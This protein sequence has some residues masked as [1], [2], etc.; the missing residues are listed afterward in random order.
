MV[1]VASSPAS[2]SSTLHHTAEIRDLFLSRATDDLSGLRPVVARSWRRSRAAGVDS[3][4][5]RGYIDEGRVDERTM[6]TA[7]PHL[8]KL[9]EVARDIG[10]Y[11]SLSSPNGVLVKPTFLREDADF[12]QGYSLLEAS[13]G[14]NAEGVALEEG[15]AVW[16]S[17]EEH[18]REDMRCNWCF[19]SLIR[20]PFHNRV[21]AVVGLTLPAARVQRLDPSSTLLM[22][23][24]VTSRIER[25][26]ETR[27]SSRERTL[28][29]EYLT[30][31]RRRG[32]AAVV[33]TD[34]KHS[35]MNS[36]ATASLEGSD[37]SVVTSYAKSVMS[38]GRDT[39]V[40][41]MLAGFGPASLEVSPVDLSASGF[42]AV[43]VVR[44]LARRSRT[45]DAPTVSRHEVP[46]SAGQL[47]ERLDGQSLSL[48]HAVDSARTAVEQRRSVAIIGEP[49]S[50]KTRLAEAIAS[51]RGDV[52]R[53]DA[54][55]SDAGTRIDEAR[56][57]ANTEFEPVLFI[58]HADELSPMDSRDLAAQL[59]GGARRTVIFTA[60]SVTDATRPIADASGALEITL[61]PLRRR[62]EDIPLLAHAI[63]SEVGDRRL[64]RRL[65]ATLT[66]SDWPGNITQLRQVVS[67]AVERSRGIEVSDDDLPESFHRMLTKGR[68]SR[69]EDA[70]LT[71][72][73]SALREAK[74]NR[75][76]AAEILEIGRS[77]FYRRMDYFRSRG[78]DL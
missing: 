7:E 3:Q 44:P 50:G 52:I 34:G 39:S 10:G 19:A 57:H 1:S 78:F 16:L 13:C 72:I 21:R 46:S 26:I 74:G 66:N 56:E 64:S 54:R 41:V 20:D 29:R 43:A 62:R 67:D 9:D 59:R 53:I 32:K 11:V 25:E 47:L 48:Q 28:L 31:S 27:M 33:V 73:R 2:V 15:R 17:P 60:A 40:E 5:D 35:F 68:L 22:L 42:G 65:V 69:L 77:T 6:L 12:A 30:I 61:A 71:E 4:A 8:L 76:L 51:V 24:G 58:A 23:E 18:F 14:S 63:A 70:E 36:A 37:L 75:R 49:G 45:L 55:D 38:S